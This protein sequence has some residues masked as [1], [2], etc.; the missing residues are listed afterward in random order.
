MPHGDLGFYT[1]YQS[2]RHCTASAHGGRHTGRDPRPRCCES[3]RCTGHMGHVILGLDRMY[4]KMCSRAL[5][6]G[7]L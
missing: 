1:G 5:K 2:L 7:F 6:G 4:I 3:D